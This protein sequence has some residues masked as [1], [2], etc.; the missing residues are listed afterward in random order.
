MYG[1]VYMSENKISGRKYIGQ[2]KSDKLDTSYVGSGIALWKAV[3]RYGK[4]NFSVRILEEC[5]SL[6][7]LNDREAYWIEHYNAVDSPEFYNLVEGGKQFNPMKGRHHTP[8][9]IEKCRLANL[10]RKYS[11]ERCQQMSETFSGEGNPR[12]GCTISDEQKEKQ[13]KSLMK[14]L[15][16]H[17]EIKEKL[18]EIAKDR[19]KNKEDHPMYGKRHSE[20]AKQKMREKAIGR[21]ASE[22]TKRKMSEAQKGKPKKKLQKPIMCVETGMRFENTEEVCKYLGLQHKS[23]QSFA[24]SARNYEAGI[25]NKA[26]GYHWKYI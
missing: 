16:E 14:T 22:E 19:F 21:K 10:G 2:H 7:E 11:E 8:E 1:Y 12:Y 24:R 18:S 5:E 17:P 15:S 23:A 13:R 26:F 9:A 20:E 4:E 3:E 6:D 25:D